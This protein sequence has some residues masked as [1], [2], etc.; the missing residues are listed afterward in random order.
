[1]YKIT[2]EAI[3]RLA[4]TETVYYRGMRY[5]AAHA[6]SDVTWNEATKQYHA[7]VQGSNIYGVTIGFGEDEQ[8]THSCNCPAHAKYPGACKHVVATLLFIAEQ[9]RWKISVGKI[10]QHTR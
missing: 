7:F 6:V 8:I 2:R 1:M 3:R 10:K 9:M 4:T 5:Y